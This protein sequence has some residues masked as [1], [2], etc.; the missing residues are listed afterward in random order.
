MSENEKYYKVL[1]GQTTAKSKIVGY[2]RLHKVHLTEAQVK[3]KECLRKECRAFKKWDCAFWNERER[4]KEIK[5]MKKERGIPSW[6]KV[7]IRTDRNGELVPTM[8]KN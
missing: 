5:Q 7:E 8:R 6:Q 2:C 4:K 1:G 3:S